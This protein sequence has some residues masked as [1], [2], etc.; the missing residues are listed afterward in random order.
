MA[1]P[2]P[3]RAGQS[4]GQAVLEARK[5]SL[6]LA[7]NSGSCALVRSWVSP[8]NVPSPSRDSARRARF[9]LWLELPAH[10]VPWGIPDPGRG[11]LGGCGEGGEFGKMDLLGGKHS[12][13]GQVRVLWGGVFVSLPSSSFGLGADVGTRIPENNPNPTPL[14]IPTA[15]S[16]CRQVLLR[17]GWVLHNFRKSRSRI[18]GAFHPNFFLHHTWCTQNPE[19]NVVRGDVEMRCFV[20]LPVFWWQIREMWSNF[21]TETGRSKALRTLNP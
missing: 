1:P 21:W 16:G 14:P 19:F 13:H 12:H 2:S 18:W 9:K 4:S 10:S 11:R 5:T 15:G 7:G 8:G 3:C 6:N 20:L 17:A